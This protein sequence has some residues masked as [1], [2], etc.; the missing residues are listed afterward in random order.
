MGISE[1]WPNYEQCEE[2]NIQLLKEV[3]MLIIVLLE[4]KLVG[5]GLEEKH[6][7]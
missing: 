5:S 4:V 7:H 3:A 6:D 2:R 1:L